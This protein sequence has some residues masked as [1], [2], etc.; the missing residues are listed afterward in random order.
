MAHPPGHES[1][2][3]GL[4]GDRTMVPMAN[5]ARL[6]RDDLRGALGAAFASKRV[7]ALL[8]AAS[9]MG[10]VLGFWTLLE[11]GILSRGGAGAIDVLAYWTAGRSLL[12]GGS[13]YAL[14]VGGFTAYLYPPVFVQ[15]VSPFSLLP[16]DA[17]VWAWRA[18]E[19]G[20]LRVA[21]GS[22]RNA[23]LA[24]LFWP[25]VVTELDAGNVHLIVAAA[26]AMSIRGDARALV[27]AALTKFASLAAVPA[28]IRL[29]RRGLLVGAGVA[30]VACAVS[31]ALA[32]QLWS[33]YLAFITRATEPH[34]DWFNLGALIWTPLRL[35]IA[36]GFALAALAWPR[37]SA[38][39]VTLAY[40]VLWL[41]GLST[42]TALVARPRG[43]RPGTMNPEPR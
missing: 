15:L 33:D 8:G 19:V 23:G 34:S 16:L 27:P 1:P 43:G 20:C 29:D 3:S 38:V 13:V 10:Y 4:A 9:V 14:P 7:R 28:A 6:T 35:A 18:L 26:V 17:F 5:V 11:H 37:L 41:H 39:A 24:I 12:D 30:L 31:I 36:A 40:P 22:W 21:V 2:S 32:P 25:P 42:L